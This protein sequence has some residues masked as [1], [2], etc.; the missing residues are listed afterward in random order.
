[1]SKRP[2]NLVFARDERPGLPSIVVLAFQHAAL[3]VVFLIYAA[4]VAKGAGF[5]PPQQQALL[6]GSLIACGLGAIMQ[7]ASPRWSSGLLV[8][9]IASPL[10]VVFGIEAGKQVGPGGIATL[11]IA[12]GIVQ[13]AMGQVLPKLRAFF[14]AEV[15]G[16]VVL[17]LGV[18]ILPLGFHGLL[19]TEPGGQEF[20]VDPQALAVGL[21]TM[22]SIVAASIWLKGS[23]RFF[24]LLIGCGAGYAAA[25]YFGLLADVGAMF[26]G[27]PILSPPR[28]V[29]P[30]FDVGL[31]L[32]AA[33]ILLAVVS[34]VDDMGVFI[35]TDRL[36][37][38]EW[39]KPD[40]AKLSRGVSS[41]GSGSIVSGFLGGG[42]LGLSS[43]NIGL[44]FATGVT[45]RIVGVAAGIIMIAASFFPA[46]LAL[47]TAM[48]DAVIGGILAY[49][50]SYFIVAGADLALSRML[51]PRRMVVI[52]L[53]VAAGIA[54]QATP[55][56]AEGSTG[57]LA[58]ILHSPLILSSLLAIGLNALMRIGIAQT[59]S[60]LVPTGGHQHDRIL[61]TLEEWGELWGL[62]RTTVAQANAAVNQ[63]I[64]A[65]ADLGEG[66]ICLE[67]RHDELNV[68]L[69]VIYSGVP[70]SIPDRAPTAE[71]MLND[72]DGVSRM[73][74]WLVRHL[75][76]RATTFTRK[77]QQGVMLR[78]ET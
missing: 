13:I 64:E 14:P 63:L 41:M 10:F 23:K 43:T 21:I 69:S 61:E 12:G 77:G 48:P 4:M 7:A 35:S 55:A 72:A 73:A 3:S 45:S 22:G 58:V 30:S 65:V 33:F 67:A 26:S 78:F 60:I 6:V 76:D 59:A 36:D 68:D 46:L 66:D 24:A 50:A 54:V 34:A 17:M 70:L 71:E 74:G 11:A 28:P 29:L 31:P 27:V 1:M 19:G 52:G 49:A 5:T 53:P 15:C 75:A 56:V 38:A 37:D 57:M 47:V 8:I 2:R 9:P 16:V 42:F 20:S 18:S 39:S 44:A 51:S 25:G 32:I 62:R 40:M